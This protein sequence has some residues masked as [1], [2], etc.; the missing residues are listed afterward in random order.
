MNKDDID[1]KKEFEDLNSTP[2]DAE[3]EE[4][5]KKKQ[6]LLENDDVIEVKTASRRDERFVAFNLVYAADRFDYAVE[7]DEII[8]NFTQGYDLKLPRNS[9]A[10]KLAT[11]VIE[12]R[13]ALD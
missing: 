10:L 5:L 3:L 6:E 11:G 8:E 2:V 1:N 12:A 7:L 13:D 9:F 4:A